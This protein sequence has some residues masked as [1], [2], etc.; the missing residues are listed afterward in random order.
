MHYDCF[1]NLLCVVQ[2][3]KRVRL[4]APSSLAMAHL[5]AVGLHTENPNHSQVASTDCACACTAAD[6]DSGKLDGR[7]MAATAACPGAVHH[8]NN[9]TGTSALIACPCNV[10]LSATTVSML[11][12]SGDNAYAPGRR[13]A[14]HPR[15]LV[16]PSD[17]QSSQHRGQP[18]VAFR[19]TCSTLP[20]PHGRLLFTA[21]CTVL[22]HPITL[23]HNTTISC[24]T[25]ASSARCLTTSLALTKDHAL[26]HPPAPLD[27]PT[28]LSLLTAAAAAAVA[29]D[30][31][32]PDVASTLAALNTLQCAR[33]LLH[34]ART[35]PA[36]LKALLLYGLTPAAAEVLTQRWDAL[37]EQGTASGDAQP[38][39]ASFFQKVF[40]ACGEEAEEV[41]SRLL[42]LKEAFGAACLQTLLAAHVEGGRWLLEHR[43]DDD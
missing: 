6:V 43:C 15:R 33:V 28:A 11:C 18:V 19:C 38:D 24:D 22:V 1:H 14:G 39:A 40:G 34:M 8:G 10:N 5:S 27:D 30:G 23:H 42:A 4:L 12:I 2:G 36:S 32:Q 9:P 35:A 31:P 20:A 7:G 26:P 16:A 25:T 21:V 3:T 17:L 41:S 37:G 13:C 29:P